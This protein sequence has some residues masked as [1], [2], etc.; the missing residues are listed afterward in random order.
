MKST[1]RAAR[2]LAAAL[3]ALALIPDETQAQVSSFNARTGA[4]VPQTGDYS[5]IS[6]ALTNKTIDGALNTLTNI[7]NSA[8]S[9]P[10]TT[11]GGQVVPLGSATANQGNGSKL[12]LSTGA[13]I[14]N[15]C[16]KFDANGNT[17]DA[18]GACATLS[19]NN[20]FTGTNT[21]TN[22]SQAQNLLWHRD[23]PSTTPFTASCG[24]A[25]SSE[26]A[27]GALTVLLPAS[28]GHDCVVALYAAHI[29]NPIY[30]DPNGSYIKSNDFDRI[31][32][33]FYLPASDG[34]SS[35]VLRFVPDGI[36]WQLEDA[37]P[38]PSS[39]YRYNL[40]NGAVRFDHDPS[41]PRTRLCPNGDGGLILSRK[42]TYVAPTCIFMADATAGASST[43]H[44]VYAMRK[45]DIHVRATGAG[46]PCPDAGKICL[47][48]D[49]G[50]I[51]YFATGSAITCVNFFGSPG[52]DVYDDPNTILADSTHIELSDVSYVAP[53]TY[54]GT[55]QPECAY[56]VLKP[57]NAPTLDPLTEVM[58][59]GVRPYE[60]LVGAVYVDAG[61]NVVDAP[62]ERNVAS[63]YS[64]APKQFQ[65]VL[66]TS[67]STSATA[68]QTPAASF[69]GQFVSFGPLNASGTV[70]VPWTAAMR[71]QA[72]AAT[73]PTGGL[74]I[75]FDQSSRGGAS[76]CTTGAALEAPDKQVVAMTQSRNIDF[77]SAGVTTAASGTAENYMHLCA[78]ISNGTMNIQGTDVTGAP[79]GTVLSATL[80]Q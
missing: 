41:N 55:I 45:G 56:T 68:Y 3:L 31:G 36:E 24:N 43:L 10:G 37:L 26:G 51:A 38:P 65:C 70:S 76:V 13:S 80:S 9:N 44:Y 61:G 54:G 28:P 18:G 42:L 12:Q 50:D 78:G 49:A 1:S 73:S 4:V 39:I 20:S 71:G 59:N 6:E 57:D 2:Y 74:A 58:V 46:T 75:I 79:G 60:T 21:F 25:V 30:I 35:F 66:A 67:T 69:Q 63:Y 47:T 34:H 11:I 19:G 64:R 7:P 32:S 72:Q 40:H 22:I 52:A 8:L 16:V 17:V 27:P 62:C 48:F 33:L 5:T 29:P 53:E 77:Q 23:N 15:D 14:A